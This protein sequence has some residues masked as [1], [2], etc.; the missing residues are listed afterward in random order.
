MTIQ[1][2]TGYTFTSSSLGTNLS[3]E[4]PWSE[5]DPSNNVLQQFQIVVQPYTVGEYA[6]GFSLIRVVKGDVIWCPKLLVVP[7]TTPPPICTTQVTIENWFSLPTFPIIDDAN[8]AYIG[9]G[10]IIVPTTAG[11]EVGIYIFKATNLPEDYDPFIAALPNFTPSCPVTLPFTAPFAGATWEVIKIGSAV[12]IEPDPPV[13]GGWQITQ[14]LIGSLTLPGD[15]N[16]GGET[17]KLPPQLPSTAIKKEKPYPFECRMETVN[18]DLLLRIGTG[19]ISYTRSNMPFVQLGA[20]SEKLQELYEKVQIVPSGWRQVGFGSQNE[21]MES[22]GGYKIQGEGIWYLCASYWDVS[23]DNGLSVPDAVQQGKPFLSLISSSGSD[24]AKIFKQTGPGLY[25]QT[26]NIESMTGYDAASTELYAD[27]MHCHSTWFNPMKYGYDVKM[28]AQVTSEPADAATTQVLTSQLSSANRNM[29][30]NIYFP[31]LPKDG[32]VVFSYGGVPGGQFYPSPWAGFNDS[33]D[34]FNALQVIP[35]LRGNIMITRTSNQNFYVTFIN[36]LQAMDVSL[37]TANSAGLESYSYDYKIE[38][39]ITGNIVLDTE[40]KFNGTQIT[41]EE[42]LTE[43]DDP[44]TIQSA[45]EFDKIVNRADMLACT[46]FGGDVT[47]SGTSPIVNKFSPNAWTDNQVANEF[48]FKANGCTGEIC[49]HPFYVKT[50]KVGESV[51]YEVCPGTINNQTPSNIYDTFILADGDIVF[52]ACSNDQVTYPA[53][54]SIG[55]ASVLPEDDDEFGYIKIAEKVNGEIVQYV[56]G[57]L[58]SDRI[59]LGTQT[60]TY[61]FARV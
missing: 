17:K 19:S 20:S 30:Q 47:F 35:A 29:I 3:I 34:L 32:F 6:T 57:S 37:L 14:K 24:V 60:A 16:G 25:T 4:Q 41:N 49:K 51:S 31:V 26:M 13:A 1:P 15:G 22:N 42:G 50:I 38:Q 44:Y 46:G 12:Y 36:D 52:L 58:W 43:A 53:V 28:I 23:D 11:V 56:T 5:L 27:W 40:P 39:F 59:K 54:S 8:S 7:G 9:D 21:W 55:N 2:G 45:N 48:Y 61:Y 18:G 33:V 10:G